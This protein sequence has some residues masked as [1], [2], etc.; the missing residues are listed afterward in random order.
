MGHSPTYRTTWIILGEDGDTLAKYCLS[1]PGILLCET[2]TLCTVPLNDTPGCPSPNKFWVLSKNCNR[3][4]GRNVRGESHYIRDTA[5]NVAC[6]MLISITPV[7]SCNTNP[8]SR[9]ISLLRKL[10]V[11]VREN[12]F[13]DET[14]GYAMVRS[15]LDIA[16]TPMAV[17]ERL[18]KWFDFPAVVQR[19]HTV[20]YSKKEVEEAMSI[21]GILNKSSFAFASLVGALAISLIT[22]GTMDVLEF[23]NSFL[24]H[25]CDSAMLLLAPV[26]ATSATTP[27][28]HLWTSSRHVIMCFWFLGIFPLSTYMRSHLIST[29]SIL[30]EPSSLDTVEELEAGLDR[31]SLFPCLINRSSDHYEC[32]VNASATLLARKICLAF[33]TNRE[34]KK[35]LT[36]HPYG[37]L[38]CALRLHHVCIVNELKK[39]YVR[40]V[41]RKLLKSKDKL[42]TVFSTTM[43][44]A[45]SP[46]I[47]KESST[48]LP[49]PKYTGAADDGPVQDWFDLLELHA[50]AASWSEREMVTNFT[51][52][53]SSEAFKFYL[54]QIF[55]NDE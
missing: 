23:K 50:T 9:F 22:L 29:M 55:Q 26:L 15:E 36:L 21:Y 13:R 25:A 39:S 45:T 27:V 54:T 20:F 19:A 8:Y 3:P 33:H 34:S 53:V 4:H 49:I 14:Y 16:F 38:K 6:M 11:S 52:Y 31:H 7:Q 10:N 12:V 44:Q 43:S 5:V 48:D 37:C 51:D 40:N 30:E 32:S 47:M 18:M 46:S 1:L 24:D 41:S 28:W 17:H 2:G 42:R 35:L